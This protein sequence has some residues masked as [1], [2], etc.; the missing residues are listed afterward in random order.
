M[1]Q[2][3]AFKRDSFQRA[4][5][6]LN[7]GI[8]LRRKPGALAKMALQRAGNDTGGRGQRGN[9]NAAMLSR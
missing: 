2:V 4:G 1:R 9:A 5:E 8:S 3:R 6:S 7:R